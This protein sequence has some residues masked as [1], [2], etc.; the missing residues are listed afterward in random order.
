MRTQP[1]GLV[2]GMLSSTDRGCITSRS[3][4]TLEKTVFWGAFSPMNHILNDTFSHLRTFTIEIIKKCI[5]FIY[6]F[7]FRF[8]V[9]CYLVRQC[10]TDESVSALC[11]RTCL[12][13]GGC[14]AGFIGTEVMRGRLIARNGLLLRYYGQSISMW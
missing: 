11:A 14:G 8:C 13:T 7:F 12:F 9:G 3:L 6:W 2:F 1:N 5:D 4:T 10:I